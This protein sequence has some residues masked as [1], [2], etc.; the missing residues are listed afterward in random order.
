METNQNLSKR[1]PMPVPSNVLAKSLSRDWC[2]PM[3]C[4]SMGFSRQEYWSGVAISYS[5]VSSQS[6]DQ[7]HVSYISYIGWRVLYEVLIW[8]DYK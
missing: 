8:M 2:D 6:R 1:G 7:T 4:L 3:D 5:R